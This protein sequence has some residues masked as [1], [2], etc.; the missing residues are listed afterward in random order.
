M[1][2]ILRVKIVEALQNFD[3]VAR[4]ETLGQL[5]KSLERFLQRTILDKPARRGRGVSI[6][7]RPFRSTITHSRTMLR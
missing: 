5:A 1:D 3:H 7:L 2:D 4:D 6:G